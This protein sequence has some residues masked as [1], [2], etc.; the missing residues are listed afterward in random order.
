MQIIIGQADVHRCNATVDFLDEVKPS[1]PPTLNDRD[2]HEH[3]VNVAV[4]IRCQSLSHNI[5]IE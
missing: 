4:N 1:Y 3:F 2:L 5:S